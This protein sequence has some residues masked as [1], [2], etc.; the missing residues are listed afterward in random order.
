[1]H[2]NVWEWVADCYVDSYR[3]APPT[4]A[5][6]SPPGCDWR[7]VRGAGWNTTASENMRTAFR[8]RR[9]AESSRD[10]VGF[11]VARAIGA[12]TRAGRDAP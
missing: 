4:G 8:L 3:G 2:G 9:F 1:M 6:V 5:A 7:V 12:E 11:R 10:S